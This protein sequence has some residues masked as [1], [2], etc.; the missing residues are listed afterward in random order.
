[1]TLAA[2]WLA[3][4]F[5]KPVLADVAC[6]WPARRGAGIRATNADRTAT[7]SVASP[8]CKRT[9]VGLW[10]LAVPL[11]KMLG[12]GPEVSNNMGE[13]P[14]ILTPCSVLQRRRAQESEAQRCRIVFGEGAR[15]ERTNMWPLPECRGPPQLHRWLRAAVPSGPRRGLRHRDGPLQDVQ[16]RRRALPFLLVQGPRADHVICFGHAHLLEN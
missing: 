13:I 16:R 6:L 1:M 4:R 9:D 11:N 3:C 2:D 14:Q 15:L 5:C 12:V 10:L 8:C 7:R